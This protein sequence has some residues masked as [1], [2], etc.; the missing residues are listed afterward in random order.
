MEQ[1]LTFAENIAS[2]ADW[3]F[4][5]DQGNETA[6]NLSAQAYLF[7]SSV[8]NDILQRKDKKIFVAKSNIC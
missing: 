1:N 7:Y 4:A 6:Q 2:E 3:A 5:V 8:V